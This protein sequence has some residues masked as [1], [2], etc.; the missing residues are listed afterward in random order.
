MLRILHDLRVG[1]L[2]LDLILSC[3]LLGFLVLFFSLLHGVVFGLLF[4]LFVLQL[5]LLFVLLLLLVF[6]LLLLL[7]CR[8]IVRIVA[9]LGRSVVAA[10]VVLGDGR[11]GRGL[12]GAGGS[13]GGIRLPGTKSSVCDVV[14][15]T[16][17]SPGRR[18]STNASRAMMAAAAKTACRRR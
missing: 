9:V 13:L 15:A 11:R 18:T 10:A 3:L 1:L 4:V 17:I 12:P 7:L 16:A 5:G 6:F 14:D 8:V 2:G